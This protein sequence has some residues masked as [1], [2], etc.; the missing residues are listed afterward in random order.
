MEREF[1]FIEVIFIVFP[2]KIKR[3]AMEGKEKN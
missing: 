1:L 3:D 2:E